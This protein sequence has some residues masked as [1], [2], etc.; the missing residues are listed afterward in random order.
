MMETSVQAQPAE[1]AAIPTRTELLF[2][3]DDP[4]IVESLSLALG[5]RYKV[6]PAANREQMTCPQ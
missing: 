4:L 2:V 3:D 5:N 6:Y 1:N